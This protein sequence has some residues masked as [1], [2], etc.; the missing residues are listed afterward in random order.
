MV[1]E[2]NKRWIRLGGQNPAMGDKKNV[3][4]IIWKL[5]LFDST[6]HWNWLKKTVSLSIVVR[7][8]QSLIVHLHV[9]SYLICENL[10]ARDEKWVGC[11]LKC[12]KSWV[13]A[14]H[15]CSIKHDCFG[16]KFICI[17]RNM[18]TWWN[19]GRLL[20]HCVLK[21]SFLFKHCSW[22]K[23]EEGINRVVTAA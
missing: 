9:L 8:L 6:Q 4:L 10:S 5:I 1:C 20:R 14:G 16:K 7:L 13:D 11:N 22:R 2:F 21:S 12:C 17:W 18:K 23:K 3:D 19:L 15:S